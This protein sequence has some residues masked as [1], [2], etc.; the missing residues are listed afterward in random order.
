[1]RRDTAAKPRTL[2]IGADIGGTFTDI[3]VIVGGE[4]VYTAKVLSTPDDYGRAILQGVGA[5]V[6]RLGTAGDA[7]EEVVHA[8]TIVTNAVLEKRGVETGL[9]TTEGFRDVLELRRIRAPRMYDLHWD[10]PAPLVSRRHRLG[11]VERVAPGGEV[12]LD[13]DEAIARERVRD[14]LASG[15][16]S[17]AICLLHSYE[18]PHHERRL[19]AIVEEEHPGFPV[20]LSSDLVPDIGEYERTSTTVVNAYTQPTVA[21]YLSRL[22][23]DLKAIGIEAPVQLLQSNGDRMGIEAAI[24][25]PVNLIQ[26]GSAA[27]VIAARAIAQAS[28]LPDV[29]VFDM[30]G[31]S[32][33]ATL[34]ENGDVLTTTQ[35]EVGADISIGSRLASGAGY[36]L[37]VPAIDVAE[38]GAGGGSIAWF[39]EGGGLRV[40]PRSAGAMPGPVS[41]GLGG[42]EPTV[43]DA[44]L[45]L[46]YLPE[47]LAGGNL[48]IDRR[49]AEAAMAERIAGRLGTSVLDA[50]FGV[51]QVV[52]ATMVRAARAVSTERGRSV[53]EFSLIGFGGSG[54][55]HAVDIAR[56]LR[57]PRVVIPPAAGL[58]SAL[59]LL[60]SQAGRQ[61]VQAIMAPVDGLDPAWLGARVAALKAKAV[62]ELAADGHASGDV[63]HQLSAVMRYEGQRS[64]LEI[65]IDSEVSAA[66]LAGLKASFHR[67]HERTYGY[68]SEAESVVMVKLVLRAQVP[69]ETDLDVFSGVGASRPESV[70]NVYFGSELGL[71]TTRV[72]GRLALTEEVV[73]GPMIVEDD[74]CTV[75]V[76]P[77]SKVWRDL[78]HGSIVIEVL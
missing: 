56:A 14:L 46:G 21:R 73:P 71:V 78:R 61:V 33:K 7:V 16:R 31:T 52:N 53:S 20:T 57:I 29:L 23:A 12:I 9:L 63:V 76:P 19:A 45:I 6:D 72:L 11:I 74:D 66:T 67:E 75:V 22:S 1:M 62:D 27:G 39:D 4:D 2:R 41:Y 64:D 50:A 18:Y 30:G 32:T 35:Y 15:V 8:T 37:L 13:L 5:I 40:G 47:E 58:L 68:R 65:P 3:V 77:N 59:G 60:L 36:T 26:S 69:R 43:T 38:V 10:K 48:R 42:T 55:L 34:I 25:R 70:R 17:I 51:R 54:P 49:A 44:N 24:T 28:Q